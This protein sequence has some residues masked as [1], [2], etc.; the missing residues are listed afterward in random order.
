MTYIDKWTM[1]G[2]NPRPLT[3]ITYKVIALPTA[4]LI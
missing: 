3:P 1:C 2:L 4:L